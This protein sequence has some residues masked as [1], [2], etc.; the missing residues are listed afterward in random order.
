MQIRFGQVNVRSLKLNIPPHVHLIVQGSPSHALRSTSPKP[1]RHWLLRLAVGTRFFRPGPSQVPASCGWAHPRPTVS[2]V[3]LREEDKAL[4]TVLLS[5]VN[6]RLL[7]NLFWAKTLSSIIAPP[8]PSPTASPSWPSP[9]SGDRAQPATTAAFKTSEN[10]SAEQ[11]RPPGE[12]P[13]SP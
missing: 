10:L 4:R 2:P 11:V 1:P 12:P 5:L 6:E 7:P 13:R 8:P 9:P 3:G